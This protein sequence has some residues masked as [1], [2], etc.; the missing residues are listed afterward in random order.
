MIVVSCY[1]SF[2]LYFSKKLFDP[3]DELYMKID[4][5]RKRKQ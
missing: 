2:I 4:I 5:L 3:M 1:Y